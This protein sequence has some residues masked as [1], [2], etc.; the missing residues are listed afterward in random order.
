M[1]NSSHDPEAVLDAVVIG[2][3]PAGLQAALTLGRVHRSVLLLDSGSYRNAAAEAMHNVLGQDGTPPAEL[4]A[5]VHAELAAYDTVTVRSLAVE[6]VAAEGDLYAVHLADGATVRARGLVLATG[7]RD[8]LPDKPGL[9]EL[10]GHEVAHCPFCHGH[11]YA[12]RPVAVL[13]AGPGAAHLTGIMGPV[14]SSL[15][16]LADGGPVEADLAPDVEVRPEPV[17]RFDRDGDGDGVR[18]SFADGSSADYAGVFVVPSLAQAAPFAEQL[19]LDLLPSGC[20]EVDL[21]GRTSRPRVHAAGD[22]A[23]LAA[24]PMPMASVLTAAASG[25]AAAV[26]MVAALL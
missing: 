7:L 24:L 9:A 22:M 11:E 17:A 14:A 12:G 23:H 5:T 20:V 21:M 25:Q 8:T 18:V 13:G 3:G 4:R 19:G 10:W 2:G 1:S 6:R 26:A 15:T 16:V